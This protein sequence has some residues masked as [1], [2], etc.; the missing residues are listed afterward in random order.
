MKL[1]INPN[2]ESPL[3]YLPD[4]TF[5]DGR[6]TALGVNQFKIQKK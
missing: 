1:P 4:Y 3:T 2:K 5:T 6:P